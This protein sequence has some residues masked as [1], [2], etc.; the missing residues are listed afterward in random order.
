MRLIDADKLQIW[1]SLRAY[2]PF[3]VCCEISD[4]IDNAPTVNPY[5][6]ILCDEQLPQCTD[7]YNVTVGVA[8]EF[9][10]FEKVTT[11]CFERIKGRDPRWIIP[12]NEAYNVIAW[13]PLPT[14]YKE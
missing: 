9:G 5:K 6:W 8:N 11:L 1:T 10:Y 3:E 13:M 4:I 7:E 2:C 14:A 12:K